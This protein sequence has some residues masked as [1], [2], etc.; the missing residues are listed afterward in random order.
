MRIEIIGP[1]GSGKSTLARKIAGYYGIPFYEKDR[2]VYRFD[3]KDEMRT[4]EEQ[5][6]IMSE[7]LAC[8]DWVTEGP[9]RDFLTET[10]P[11]D[12]LIII[13]HP[14]KR[15]CMFRVTKRWLEQVL[16]IRDYRISRNPKTLYYQYKN[17]FLFDR[18]LER[19]YREIRGATDAQIVEFST[20]DSSE[21][22]FEYVLEMFPIEGDRRMDV[23]SLDILK[24]R[25][26]R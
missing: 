22:A 13:L 4:A 12:D 20:R 18:R 7:M 3:P 25:D 21:K 11:L 16:E 6:R 1:A 2:I 8:G 23:G 19:R 9:D 5:E 10:Y 14:P 26:N 17:Q 15:V 24:I